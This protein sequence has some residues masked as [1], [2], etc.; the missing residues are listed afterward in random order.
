MR[1]I[2]LE[3][4]NFCYIWIFCTIYGNHL[5]SFLFSQKF[6]GSYQQVWSSIVETRVCQVHANSATQ[7][8]GILDIENAQIQIKPG[9]LDLFR[10]PE[11]LIFNLAQ[12][13]SNTSKCP[14]AK[15]TPNV[16]PKKI[17]FLEKLWIFWKIW[18]THELLG[19]V[20][21]LQNIFWLTKFNLL[22]WT[23]Q[24]LIVWKWKISGMETEENSIESIFSW[25]LFSFLLD[26]QNPER[27]IRGDICWCLHWCLGRWWLQWDSEVL[28]YWLWRLLV[29]IWLGDLR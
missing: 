8:W 17:K 3:I 10:L 19:D 28:V 25:K 6:P 12:G 18:R 15:L 9:C 14:W 26:F 4:L 13:V 2:Q 21:K 5:F 16:F 24:N 7:F 11:I 29:S 22:G 20:R 1:E 27:R 23:A